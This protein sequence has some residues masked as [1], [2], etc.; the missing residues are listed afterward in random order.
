MIEKKQLG[1]LKQQIFKKLGTCIFI[2]NKA[3]HFSSGCPTLS[4]NVSPCPTRQSENSILGHLG[5]TKQALLNLDSSWGRLM[6]N[7]ACAYVDSQSYKLFPKIAPKAFKNI[8]NQ[9]SVL[10][11]L[12]LVLADPDVYHGV[13]TLC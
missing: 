12:V 7:K 3:L 11:V 10:E 8:N 6:Q 5:E 9:V 4:L 1:N 13:F 2:R